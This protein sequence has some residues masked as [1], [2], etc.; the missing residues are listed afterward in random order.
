MT[1]RP[2][3]VVAW[4]FRSD[5]GNGFHPWKF[6][7]E[8]QFNEHKVEAGYYDPAVETQ[9][10]ALIPIAALQSANA[11]LAAVLGKVDRMVD[12]MAWLAVQNSGGCEGSWIRYREETY[13][14]LAEDLRYLRRAAAGEG[15]ANQGD[16]E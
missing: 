1:A 13:A 11:R 5:W 16:G 15:G 2:D 3:E 12:R 6:C 14:G 4:Q 7:D 9:Y 8:A 10:R